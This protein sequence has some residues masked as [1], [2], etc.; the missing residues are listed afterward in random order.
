MPAE[1]RE[2]GPSY[3]AANPAGVKAWMELE[4]KALIG[5]EYRQTLR[6]EITQAKLKETQAADAADRRHCGP[7]DAAVDLA[8]DR[9]RDSEQPAGADARGRALVVLGAAGDLQSRRAR[10][11]RQPVEIEAKGRTPS[12][13]QGTYMDDPAGYVIQYI[14]EGMQ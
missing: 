7:V 3:R 12:G 4:H 11:H 8:N 1:F 14:P 9:G 2:L 5:S 13:S 10:L 6:N